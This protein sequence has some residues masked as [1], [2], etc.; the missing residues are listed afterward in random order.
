VIRTFQGVANHQDGDFIFVSEWTGSQKDMFVEA[1]EKGSNVW[2]SKTF[3][4][5][6][7][8]I[9]GLPEI[10]FDTE[11]WVG[12]LCAR[13]GETCLKPK[14]LCKHSKGGV[15]SPPRVKFKA[16]IE[17]DKVTLTEEETS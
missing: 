1:N 15:C 7:G 4:G 10:L 8:G 11:Y 12:M 2:I 5:S 3:A 9:F 13:W 16:V 14:T 6:F 17:I